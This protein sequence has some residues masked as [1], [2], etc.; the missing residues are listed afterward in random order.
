MLGERANALPEGG[1]AKLCWAAIEDCCR[2]LYKC[3]VAIEDRY[4]LAQLVVLRSPALWAG[5]RRHTSTGCFALLPQPG[6]VKDLWTYVHR[7][8]RVATKR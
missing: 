8:L 1:I 7:L 5:E 4:Q 6:Q 2:S 3:R